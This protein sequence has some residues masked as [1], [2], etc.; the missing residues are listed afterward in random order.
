MADLKPR[1]RWTIAMIVPVLLIGVN[2]CGA[3]V[4]YRDSFNG[5]AVGQP[6]AQP[7][8]GTATASGDAEIAANPQDPGSSDR[9]LRLGRPVPTQ[10]GGEYIGTF[11]ETVLNTN[12]SVALVGFIPAA[13]RMMMSVF[14]EAAPPGPPVPFLHIDLL[15]D[16]NIR[17]NDSTVVGTYAFDTLIGFVIGFELT[18][19][20][21]VA[22]ILIRGGGEDASLTVPIPANVA[23]FGLGRV[24][25]FAPFEGVNAPAGA[26][27]VN[28]VV[29]TR[30]SN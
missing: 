26:F 7:E 13:S 27:L 28:D 8:I 30:R 19:S 12:G 5:P 10:P 23:G 2:G 22:N 9:W 24:R 16:G 4:I 18:A 6:P 1:R 14:F 20:P 25:V 15:K 29:A 3:T 11:T 17:V 21:P